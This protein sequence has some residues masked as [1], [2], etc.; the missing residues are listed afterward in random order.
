[1]T[2]K[3]REAVRAN[4]CSGCLHWSMVDKK[5]ISEDCVG[6]QGAMAGAQAAQALI[7]EAALE[8]DAQSIGTWLRDQLDKLKPKA[9]TCRQC[10]EPVPR[11][12][13]NAPCSC[14]SRVI[15]G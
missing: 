8:Q 3:T 9:E 1:M 11:N 2:D 12:L 7:L 5:C 10:H 15:Q 4:V 14:G 6:F 13:G